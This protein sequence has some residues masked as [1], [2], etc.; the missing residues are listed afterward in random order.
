[1]DASFL[2]AAAAEY[3]STWDNNIGK[4]LEDYDANRALFMEQLRTGKR[5]L[6]RKP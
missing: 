1:M 2:Y 4:A 6:K 3:P 5:T